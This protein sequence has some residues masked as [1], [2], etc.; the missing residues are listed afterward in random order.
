MAQLM[1]PTALK[2]ME[3]AMALTFPLR[4]PSSLILF[5]AAAAFAAL[6]VFSFFSFLSLSFSSSFFP[7]ELASS[8]S[9]S[10]TFSSSLMYWLS[11][12]L[13]S[14][15]F[16]VEPKSVILPSFRTYRKGFKFITEKKCLYDFFF[17]LPL[18]SQ[19]AGECLSCVWPGSWLSSSGCPGCQ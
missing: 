7:P 15:S 14:S 17:N 5:S 2:Y 18:C 19:P 1:Y 12:E 4:T 16:E 8:F 3:Y 10:W 11:S 6:P 13:A 9:S